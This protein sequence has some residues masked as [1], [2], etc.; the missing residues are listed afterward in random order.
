MLKIRMPNAPPRS[1]EIWSRKSWKSMWSFSEPGIV[2][3][4]ARGRSGLCCLVASCREVVVECL[5]F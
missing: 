1:R 4:G 2:V 3:D 5:T